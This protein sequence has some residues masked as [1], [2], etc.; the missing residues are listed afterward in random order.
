MNSRG[1]T[2]IEMLMALA[3]LA[4]LVS[5]GAAWLSSTIRASERLGALRGAS[6]I[7]SVFTR[8]QEDLVVGDFEPRVVTGQRLPRVRAVDGSLE[9]DLRAGVTHTYRLASEPGQ[10]TLVREE[11]ARGSTSV[12]RLLADVLDFSCVI[13]DDERWLD[14]TLKTLVASN[15]GSLGVDGDRTIQRRYRLR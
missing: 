4:A 2:M 6:A 1:L 15:A 7:D 8:I 14:V 13:D 9:I 10:R 3:L 5:G 11:R 12:R